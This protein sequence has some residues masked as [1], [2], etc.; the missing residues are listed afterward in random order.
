MA[1]NAALQAALDQ[2]TARPWQIHSLGD[3]LPIDQLPTPALVLDADAF[4]RNLARMA[5]FLG[6]K[7]KGFRPHAKTHKCP[8]IA[9]RQIEAGAAGI[10]V[11]KVGEAAVMVNAGIDRV[12]VTSPVVDAARAELVADLAARCERFDVVVDSRIGLEALVQAAGRPGVDIGVLIDVDIAMGRTGNRHVEEIIR[13]AEAAATTPGLRYRG[14]QHYA[15]HVMHVKGHAKRREKSLRLWESV[16]TI[17]AALA[18]RGL[19]P[20]VVTGGGTG[21]YDIDCDVAEITDLQV[22]SYIFMDQE[23]RL[24]GGRDSDWFDDFEVSLQVLTT[25]IS[26]P[27]P[28]AI[29]VD[30]GYKSFA[31]D[32]VNP[33]PIDLTETE[34][35]FAGDEHGVLILKAPTQEPLLGSVQRF[36]APHCD[37][38]VN[39]YDWYWI[40]REGMVTE[41]WPIAARGC[42]W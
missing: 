10:C 7:G 25:A 2:V 18:D 5:A 3:A 16:A 20:E 34:F 29:T 31:S 1:R 28:A 42:S 14:I 8:V 27:T 37:P 17:V 36:I 12:L 32:S 24:V 41:T 23:Y 13:L 26:Q 33:E 6:A 22:G 39:L 35:R 4:E 9:A 40:C 38:T 30:G 11:A 15:G 21:T 19:A